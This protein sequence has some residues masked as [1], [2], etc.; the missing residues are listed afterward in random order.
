MEGAVFDCP[1]EW[2][3][4][5]PSG[6]RAIH[7]PADL[8]AKPWDLL[9]LTARG[10]Q[11][12]GAADRPRCR[13]L[14]IPGDCDGKLSALLGAETVVSYGLSPRDS[15]TLSSLTEPVLCVQRALPRV[16]GGMVEPQ[17]LPLGDLPGRA[18]ELLPLLGAWLL[19]ESGEEDFLGDFPV[20]R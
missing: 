20:F 8:T 13:I 9:A 4:F 6:V 7:N 15:L 11:R 1:S 10:C 19:T 5:L 14:L 12:L 3:A 2:E 16:D 18:E 17:E